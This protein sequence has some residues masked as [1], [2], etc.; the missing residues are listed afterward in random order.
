M[1]PQAVLAAS[2]AARSASVGATWARL[3]PVVLLPAGW[4][5]PATCGNLPS[6]AI[7]VGRTRAGLP[8]GAQAIGPYLEDRTTIGFAALAEREFGGF[9][10]PPGF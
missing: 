8:F 10:A 1:I 4:S 7:P 6:T 3:V 2:R 9:T 5:G